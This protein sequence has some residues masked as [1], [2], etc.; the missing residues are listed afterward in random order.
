[1]ISYER[2][3]QA[4]RRIR[5]YLQNDGG[6]VELVEVVDNDVKVKFL[7]TCAGCPS[8]ILTLTLGLEV[9]IRQEVPELR[10]VE[11]V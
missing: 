2:V 11:L 9:A 3:E 10:S 1:M 7:G 8:A 4:V 5:P 6:D